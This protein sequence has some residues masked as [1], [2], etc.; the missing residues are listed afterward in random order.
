MHAHNQSHP[1][2]QGRTIRWAGHYDLLVKLLALGREKALREETIHLAA[3][4]PGAIVLDV[5]CGTG[6]LTL[7]AKASAGEH[8]AVYGIDAAPEMIEVA[9]QKATEQKRDVNFQVGLIESI[10]FPDNMFDVVLSS[11]MF[12]HL[13][14][15]LKRRGLEEIY[16]VLKPGG[17]ILVVDARRPTNVSQHL[18]MFFLLHQGLTSGVDDLIPLMESAGYVGIKAGAMRWKSLGFVGGQRTTS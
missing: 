3:V 15:D 14:G 18:G 17:R 2:T 10:P 9:L 16:R 13:P 4:P 1:T 12:H 7:R 11:L 6:S 8:G 5:G